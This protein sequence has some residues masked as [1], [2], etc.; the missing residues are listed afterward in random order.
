MHN[1]VRSLV[2][3]SVALAT[4]A[5]PVKK[6]M[7]STFINVPF[8]FTVGNQTLPAGRY[9]VVGDY[10]GSAVRLTGP[11]GSYTWLTFPGDANPSD[12]RV[13]LKFD[14]LGSVHALRAIQYGSMATPQLD[15]EAVAHEGQTS[16]VELGK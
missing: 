7:A 3:A 2:L 12:H 1:T 8:A 16:E 6:A 11:S 13:V 15:K 10:A 14:D 5:F 9:T 4:A